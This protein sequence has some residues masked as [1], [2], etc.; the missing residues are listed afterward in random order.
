MHPQKGSERKPEVLE[1]Q[2]AHGQ[3][4]PKSSQRHS[5]KETESFLNGCIFWSIILIVTV[6]LALLGALWVFLRITGLGES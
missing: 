2:G 6:P 1:Y 3:D 5:A 4:D